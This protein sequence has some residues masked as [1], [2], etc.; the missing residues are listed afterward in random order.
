[1]LSTYYVVKSEYYQ[2]FIVDRI[3]KSMEGLKAKLE[4]AYKASK[5]RKVNIISHSMGGLL[6]SCFL[7]LHRDVRIF[8]WATSWILSNFSE[9]CWQKWSL[10]FLEEAWLINFNHSLA[11]VFQVC[12]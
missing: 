2:Y 4:A 12:E 11:V 8:L 6:V 1:M 10:Y 5:G 3:E 9:E 7:S